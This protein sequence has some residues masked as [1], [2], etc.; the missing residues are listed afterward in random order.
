[1]Q[2]P[3]GAPAWRYHELSKHTPESVRASGW[4]VQWSSRPHPFKDYRDLTPVTLPGDVPEHSVP[5]LEALQPDGDALTPPLTMAELGRLLRLGAGVLRTR[6]VPPGDVYHFRTYSSAGGL[7]PL[8]LYVACAKLPGLDAGLYHFHPLELNLRPLHAA[9]VRGLLAELADAPRL[10]RAGAVFVVTGILGRETWKY[11]LRGYRHLYWDAGTMLANLVSLASSARLD[12][13]VVSGFVDA[14]LCELLAVDGAREAPIALLA[15]GDAPAASGRGRAIGR[16]RD[17]S[18]GSPPATGV[19]RGPQTAPRD[20]EAMLL[21]RAS[22]F[23]SAEE[24]RSWRRAGASWSSARAGGGEPAPDAAGPSPPAH[25]SVD[26]LDRV[27]RRRGSA[28]AFSS[29]SIGADELRAILVRASRPLAADV[30]ELIEIR[31]LANAVDGI[32]PGAYRFSNGRFELLGHGRFRRV[33]GQL[34]LDQVLGARAAATHFLLAD[35]GLVL[36][37]LGDRGY[38]AAQLEAGLRAGLMYLATYAQ[39]LGATAL[40]FYDDE[41]TTFLAPG[42]SPMLS[43]AIGVDPSR[44]DLSRC[45]D[46]LLERNPTLRL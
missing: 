32:E 5:A 10:R 21:H 9:D 42:L 46:A 33:A 43:I 38:R 22:A 11:G 37:R 45:R 26:S 30:S 15:V 13:H 3:R 12:A 31:L 1:M 20:A 6:R 23:E 17:A 41:V 4:R 24:V 35:L 2:Q 44:A 25:L 39:C 29:E 8:E 7:Y 16:A 36:E 27:I 18:A 19:A 28:R 34:C 40:T 14:E